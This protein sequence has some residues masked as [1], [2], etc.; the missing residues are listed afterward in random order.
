M[1]PNDRLY[2]FPLP[3]KPEGL[4]VEQLSD[5][6]GGTDDCALCGCFYSCLAE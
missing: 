2:Y 4:T 3:P 6:V 1:E 5:M